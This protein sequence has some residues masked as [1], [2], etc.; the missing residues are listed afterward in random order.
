[1]ESV[2]SRHLLEAIAAWAEPCGR[3]VDILLEVHISRDSAKQGFLPSEVM[4]LMDEVSSGAFPSVRVKGL[5]A[6]ASLSDDENLIDTEFAS[7]KSLLDDIRHRHPQ[8]GDIFT[9]L[10]IG[11]S[12][13]WRIAVRHGATEVRIG[14]DIFG[15][16]EY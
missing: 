3:I 11:M 12:S 7:V 6:M 9:T 4:D 10:S 13:D 5:M 15:P 1:M 14:T 2:D 16:R 8:L